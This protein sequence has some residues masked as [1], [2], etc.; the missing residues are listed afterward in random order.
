MGPLHG[1]FETSPGEGE[2]ALLLGGDAALYDIAPCGG[3]GMVDV[4]D[5]IALLDAFEGMYACTCPGGGDGW[6]LTG[7]ARTNPATDFLGTTDNVALDIRVNNLRVMRY[8]PNATSPNVIGGFSGNTVTAG[9]IGATIAGGGQTDDGLGDP[10]N[11]RVT[12]D[13]GTI[14]GGRGNQTGDDAGTTTDQPSATIG[15]GSFNTASGLSSTVSGGQSNTASGVHSTVGG[16]FLNTASGNPS[17]VGGGQLNTAS[18]VHSTVGGGSNSMASGQWSTVPGGRLNQAGGNSSFAA[19]TR[20]KVRDEAAAGDADGDE[21]TFVWA[22]STG[23]DFTS[24]GPDQFLIRAAGGVGINTNSPNGTLHVQSGLNLNVGTNFDDRIAPLVVG[25]GN[26]TGTALLID[27]NQIEQA[28]NNELFVNFNSAARL[29][30]NQGGGDVA[31]RRGSASH[32]IH[33]GS[34]NTNGNGAH[35]TDAGAWTNGSSREWKENFEAVDKQVV[36]R[37]VAALPVTQWR[38]KGEDSS[39]HIGP[40]AEEFRAAFGL[41]HDDQYITTVDADG[42]ALAAIQGLHQLV[43]EKDCRIEEL[44]DRIASLE[45][46]IKTIALDGE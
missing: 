21:G 20:A 42:V 13:Y 38:Y 19:G 12:D 44:E 5:L 6:G 3:N 40:V 23:S 32:V 4:D 22:D 29:N 8:E 10:D 36:L 35:L 7:N 27:G 17:T 15:G 16:G 34:D 31:I 24:T 26:G 18:G 41:G 11:N 45:R 14:G 1:E 39:L 2:D 25:D 46:I 37:K 30:L 33:V 43:E 9:V 28:A